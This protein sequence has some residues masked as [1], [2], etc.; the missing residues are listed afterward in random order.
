MLKKVS[1]L[2]IFIAIVQL[3]FAGGVFATEALE[4]DQE[5]IQQERESIQSELSEAEEELVKLAQQL[6]EINSEIKNINN[7]IEENERMIVDTEEQVKANE[8][9]M[10]VLELEIELLQNDIDQ[11]I[12]LLKERAS[13]Y[14]RNGVETASY[15]EVILG[16]ESFGDFI[17][18]IVTISRI[19]QADSNFI[20]QLEVN[21]KELEGIQGE[22]EQT[23]RDLDDQLIM[24]ERLQE[25]IKDQKELTVKL[26][27]EVKNN[28]NKQE[29]IIRKLVDKDKDLA[30]QEDNVRK[31]IADEIRRQEEARREAERQAELAAQAEREANRQL[32]HNNSSSS[33]SSTGEWRSFKATAYTAYCTG[34]SGITFTG[35][36]LR[37]NPDAKVIAVDPRVIPLGSYVEVRGH[38][39]FLAADTG[40]AIIGNKIDIFMP[41]RS[42]ALRFGLRDVQIRVLD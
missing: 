41:N 37:N 28:E 8:A 3:F 31:R 36:D 2:A 39:T 14:Q 4:K 22:Y 11:R 32:S 38:G 16:S 21:Q 20:E 26:R 18:R 35:V 6:E 10:E 15:I 29:S 1:K 27:D 42:D 24:L 23:I 5:R 9:E 25:D 30:S 33:S 40:G 19:A 34:C 7:A 13:S 17:S 12:E